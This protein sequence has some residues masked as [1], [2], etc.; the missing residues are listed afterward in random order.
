MCAA[1]YEV[2]PEDQAINDMIALVGESVAD[3]LVDDCVVDASRAQIAALLVLEIRSV[4]NLNK[5]SSMFDKSGWLGGR[6][7]S[8]V[9][10]VALTHTHT[11]TYTPGWP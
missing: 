11:H 2:D 4:R 8:L 6:I 10:L 7:E 1:L 5:M 9:S 3:T